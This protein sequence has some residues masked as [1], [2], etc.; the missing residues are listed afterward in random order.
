MIVI[1][2]T[3][4]ILKIIN[5]LSLSFNGCNS[6]GEIFGI[7]FEPVKFP[8]IFWLYPTFTGKGFICSIRK[9]GLLLTNHS[10]SALFYSIVT[11]YLLGL[12]LRIN[13]QRFY[14]RLK[15]V[16]VKNFG[17]PGRRPGISKFCLARFKS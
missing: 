17:I 8:S 13:K 6:L 16:F 7:F 12:C 4:N 10:K 15:F 1:F 14:D 9:R 3:C 11:I 2:L 5:I